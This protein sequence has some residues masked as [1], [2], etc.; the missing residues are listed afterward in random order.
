MYTKISIEKLCTEY[1][2]KM[3]SIDSELKDSYSRDTKVCVQCSI[4]GCNETVSKTL[5]NLFTNKNFGCKI[6]SK[7]L[8]GNKIKKTKHEFNLDK[9][10]NQDDGKRYS[11]EQ[12]SIMECRPTLFEICHKLKITQYHNLQKS[13]LIEAIVERQNKLDQLQG[14]SEY[15]EEVHQDNNQITVYETIQS[16]NTNGRSNL[17][18]HLKTQFLEK[19]YHFEFDNQ[20]WVQ[21][22]SVANFLEY[23][24]PSLAIRD[25]ID[26][27]D[28]KMF[29]EF[30]EHIKIDIMRNQKIKENCHKLD[31]KTMFINENGLWKILYRTKMPIATGKKRALE[32]V[33]VATT[34]MY[35]SKGIYKIGKSDNSKKRI[36]NMNT[37]RIPEDEMYI[38]HFASCY[39]G[40]KTEKLI[41][42]T[43]NNYRVV[44]NRE[45]FKLSLSEIKQVVDDVCFESHL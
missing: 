9:A 2:T 19:H 14:I 34:K 40:L 3:L 5:R 7:V 42:N 6:H 17:T 15:N 33:Y 10:T 4:H 8:K 45:F 32:E 26:V 31:S 37:S 25:M 28:K 20:V 38:C 39:D 30:P 22:K 24:E 11:Y 36:K 18:Q 21:G 1:G 27:D 13:A 12:L 16:K 23:K 43:L 44:P 29:H 35:E 41:H